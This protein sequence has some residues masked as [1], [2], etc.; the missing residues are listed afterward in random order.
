MPLQRTKWKALGE[1]FETRPEPIN[2][3]IPTGTNWTLDNETSKRA[4]QLPLRFSKYVHQLANEPS[5]GLFHVQAHVKKSVPRCIEVK[6][7]LKWFLI[8]Y[9]RMKSATAL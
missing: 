2:L 3:I 6:V 8:I 5:L 4:S 7:K 1:V 9:E